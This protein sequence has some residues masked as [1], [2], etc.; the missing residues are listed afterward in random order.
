M[1]TPLL[2]GGPTDNG[3]AGAAW[4]FT[5]SG[6]TWSQLGSKLTGSVEVGEGQ[7]G[8]SVA[9]SSEGNTALIGRLGRQQERG[10]GLGVREQL[11]DGRNESRLGGHADHGDPE[12]TVNPN[13][14]E[15]SKCEFEY[16]TNDRIRIDPGLLLLAAGQRARAR[17]RCPRRSRV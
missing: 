17:S 13:G 16:G 12:R 7:F 14:A 1:G 6:A 10:R 11:A 9:L 4:V 2:I 3:G 8:Y 5:H 15:V